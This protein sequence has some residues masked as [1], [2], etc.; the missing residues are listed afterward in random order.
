MGLAACAA[1]T[2]SCSRGAPAQ[3][4]PQTMTLG[5][6]THFAQGWPATRLDLARKAGA[7]SL[8]D[9]VPWARVETVPGRYTFEGAGVAALDSFCRKGGSLLLVAVPL[10]PLYD[11][12][13]ALRSPGAKAA[14]AGYIAALQKH[15]ASCLAAIEIGNEINSMDSRQLFRPGETGGDPL[16]EYVDLVRTARETLRARGGTAKILGGSSNMIATGFL[17]SLFARGLLDAADA[18]AVH[19]YRSQAENLD[20]ELAHLADVM[21]RRGKPLPVW[22][23]EFSDNYPMPEMAAPQL[24]KA[25]TLLAAGGVEA[26]HWYALVDQKWFRNMGLYDADGRTKPAAQAFSLIERELLAHGRP[27]RVDPG[28]PNVRLYRFG[29]DAWVAWGASGRI[30]FDASARLLDA[31]GQ[32]LSGTEAD[33]N[34]DPVVALRSA[35]PTFT[36]GPVLADSLL[37]Y[38]SA[39]WRYLARKADGTERS[40][41]WLD[42]QWTTYHGDRFL[43]PLWIGDVAGAPAG[44]GTGAIHAIIRYTA[45]AARKVSI[46]VCIDKQPGGDGIDVALRHGKTDL[47]AALVTT[48]QR[49][50]LRDVALGTGDT[51]DLVVGPNA[52]SG[53]DGFRYRI[54]IYAEPHVPAADCPARAVPVYPAKI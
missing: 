54:R 31:R 27:E 26:A 51:V 4:S 13:G 23:S 45:P 1:L 14:F 15:F 35:R 38:G 33:L 53:R 44:E 37:G 32:P 40:L 43:R 46:A 19:P 18:V 25:A 11:E 49:F 24:V 21:R 5:V 10:N 28:D 20:V 3:T 29:T 12:G 42:G 50:D 36:P 17:D 52:K 2:T 6:Q 47:A 8:R 16:R 9:S 41:P 7:P 39:D 30:A 34:D 48:S 22:A